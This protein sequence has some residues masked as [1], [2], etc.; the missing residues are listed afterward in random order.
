MAQSVKINPTPKKEDR[1]AGDFFKLGEDVYILSQGISSK[2]LLV[3]LA[4]GRI[5]RPNDEDPFAG[6][7]H[8]FT[9]VPKLSEINIIV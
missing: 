9:K 6:Y 5:Y 1:K 2:Q 7:S 4:T 8:E 3:N